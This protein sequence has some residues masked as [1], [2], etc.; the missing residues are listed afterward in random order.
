MTAFS[1][2]AGSRDGFAREIPMC[3][4][5][6]KWIRL[7]TSMVNGVTWSISP[8]TI[9]SKPSRMPMTLTSS[10]QLRI[11]AALMTLLMPGAGPPA[12]RI[13]SFSPSCGICLAPR[14]ITAGR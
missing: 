5:P 2:P 6:R 11:V 14:R 13:A 7:T 4:P 1:R 8:C 3:D 10:R 12:T 9:H